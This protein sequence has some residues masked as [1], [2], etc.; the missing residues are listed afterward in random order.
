M[1]ASESDD[2]AGEE[3]R[4]EEG[5][6]GWCW[7]SLQH[8]GSGP[9]HLVVPLLVQPR[10]QQ[11]PASTGVATEPSHPLG[12]DSLACLITQPN[13]H[14]HLLLLLQQPRYDFVQAEA[15]RRGILQA[16]DETLAP[17]PLVFLLHSLLQVPHLPSLPFPPLTLALLLLPALA[18]SSRRRVAPGSGSVSGEEEQLGRDLLVLPSVRAV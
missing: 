17:L 11:H 3:E 10:D 2:G 7:G 12:E 9:K 15:D 13:Q 5:E 16:E 8:Q 6:L 1:G 4:V 18:V 14:H